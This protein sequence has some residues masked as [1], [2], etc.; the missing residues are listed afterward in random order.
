MYYRRGKRDYKRKIKLFKCIPIFILV[1][2]PLIYYNILM[3]SVKQD[4]I[5]QKSM[6]EVAKI[7]N[8]E[9]QILSGET[10]NT[11]YISA[12]GTSTEGTDIN[13]PMSLATAN[14]KTF[15]GNEKILFKRGDIFYGTIQFKVEAEDGTMAY[16]GSYGEGEKPIISG[17]AT[18]INK[19]AWQEEGELYKIDIS[20]SSNLSGFK[21]G[22]YEPYNIGF[23]R[24]EEG[25]I[26][27][28]RKA[29]K[30]QLL[31]DMDFYCNG[32]FLYVKCEQN[33]NEKYGQLKI[34]ARNDLVVVYTNTIVDGLNIQDTGAHG[35]VKKSDKIK[36]VYIHDCI[37]QNIGGSVLKEELVRYGNGIEFYNGTVENALIENNMFRNI[38]DVGFTMQGTSGYWE[39]IVVRNNIFIANAQNSE[40]WNSGNA[41]GITNYE[42]TN[43]LQ[44]N[45]GRGWGYEARPNKTVVSNYLMYDFTKTLLASY[46]NNISYNTRRIYS[47]SSNTLEKYKESIEIDNNK[48]YYN[49]DAY[50]L[51][52]IYTMGQLEEFRKEYNKDITSK[53][54]DLTEQELTKVNNINILT[55]NDYNEIKTYYETL[56]KDFTYTDAIIP[57]QEKYT[58]FK[59]QNQTIIT[60]AGIATKITQLETYLQQANST[61]TTQE[62]L[63]QQINQTYELG[64]T[65]LTTYLNNNLN[66]TEDEL[67]SILQQINEI[68]QTY[69]TLYSLLQTQE[70]VDF[71]NIQNQITET[72][73]V[74]AQ[75]QTIGLTQVT[76]LINNSKTII[77]SELQDTIK[78]TAATYL[79]DWAQKLLDIDIINYINQN[80]PD[81]TYSTTSLTNKDVTVTMTTNYYIQIT[82]N[83]GNPTYTFTKNDSF[84]FQYTVRNKPYTITA[85]VTNIDKTPPTITGVEEGELYY[86]E[87]EIVP[88]ITDTNLK[89]VV[90]Y[91]NGVQIDYEIG[92]PLIVEGL[93]K[94]VA[95]DEAGNTTTVQFQVMEKPDEKYIMQESS[96]QNIK[97]NTT[98]TKFDAKVKIQETY[99][100]ERKTEKE[101]IQLKATDTIAS[102]DILTTQTGQKYT[103]IVAGDLT[104]DGLVDIQDFVRMRRYLLGL[105][106]LDEVETLAADANVD[107]KD[108][109]IND[110]IRIR[111][112]ILNQLAGI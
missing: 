69:N 26:F 65:I 99:T 59:Q 100:I 36:N 22:G 62:N 3:S 67:L 50:I 91:I 64:T 9:T 13:D 61:N 25:R 10:G 58:Q 42:F 41:E 16:I 70:T 19:D 107:S 84:T 75:Y 85:M 76:T 55:S 72:E 95:T 5:K 112:L 6:I 79:V 20:N 77:Q 71:T 40:I 109:S 94:M 44:I 4:D 54:R 56:E 89:E 86:I 73:Q 57:I 35:I 14:K 33:P 105:R 34:V 47:I 12:T 102:G 46:K 52:E 66:I 92:Q 32:T 108:L 60:T 78:S 80:P 23:I 97:Y 39:N 31:N 96:I 98:K 1:I 11:Y 93:Y 28:N 7:K 49:N 111:I 27:G 101:T 90:L 2:I 29:S 104:K 110:Y 18:I 53:F 68:G 48:E 43:N 38:Y 87:Q 82:N 15:Y 17:A 63:T 8:F 21:S 45:T 106:E 74:I 88:Q 37:I 51:N 81:L 83:N 30:D 24:T 103:L